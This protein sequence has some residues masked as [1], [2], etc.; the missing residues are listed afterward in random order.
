MWGIGRGVNVPRLPPLLL[1]LCCGDIGHGRYL[2]YG[3]CVTGRRYRALGFIIV[4]RVPHVIEGI[5][6]IHLR[7]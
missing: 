5:Q 6:R 1:S 2:R 3:G 7:H 4:V